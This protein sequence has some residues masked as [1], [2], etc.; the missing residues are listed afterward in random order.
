MEHDL[1]AQFKEALAGHDW[2]YNMSDDYSVYCRGRD[3]ANKIHNL[4]RQ[5]LAAGL[6]DQADAIY[7][8][9]QNRKRY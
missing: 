1:L 2:Y 6:G 9:A 3:Q 8:A 5:C 4:R 7:E